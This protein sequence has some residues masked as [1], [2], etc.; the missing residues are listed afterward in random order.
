MASGN[1]NTSQPTST[2]VVVVLPLAKPFS[3]I[4]K[5][6]VFANE[7]FKRWQERVLFFLD[8]HGVAYAL[9]HTQLAPTI[10]AKLQESWQ[11]ANKICRHTILQMLSNELFHVH[12]SCKEA[13]TIWKALMTKFT[14]KYATKQKF[15]VGKYY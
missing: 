13:K 6:E 10:D 12:S 5:I 1:V 2:L 9:T 4:S 14:N 8:I 7:N 11:Y 3:D 15:V